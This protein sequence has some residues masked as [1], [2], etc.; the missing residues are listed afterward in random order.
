MPPK[1]SIASTPSAT[2]VT[3]PMSATCSTRCSRAS[4]PIR[5]I[6]TLS[7]S[8]EQ[9]ELAADLVPTTADPAELDQVVTELEASPLVRSATW[10]V[11][12]TA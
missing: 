3:S 2:A 8:E 9:V 7:E 10:S 4:Y 1:R 6:E 12:T 5:S 11:G